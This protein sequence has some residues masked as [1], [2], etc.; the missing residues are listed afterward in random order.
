MASLGK[1]YQKN[2]ERAYSMISFKGFSYPKEVILQA[3]RWY[4][5]L[6]VALK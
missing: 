4:V 2:G 5:A 3:V 6:T 1:L